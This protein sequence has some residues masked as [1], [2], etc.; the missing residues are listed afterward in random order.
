[1]RK[2]GHLPM[3]HSATLQVCLASKSAA[4]GSVF[5]GRLPNSQLEVEGRP[6]VTSV[7]DDEPTTW[8]YV[9]ET[10]FETLEIPLL[11][12]RHF[13]FS[14]PGPG[15]M[16]VVIVSQSM[17]RKLWPGQDPIGKRFKYNAPGSVAK[18]W[19][20]IVGVVGDT[21]QNGP[22]T[23]P[24]SIIYY[25][26]RQ[27]VWDALVLIARTES[28]PVAMEAAIGDQIHRIDKTIPR[29]EPA[30]VEQQLWELESQRRFQIELLALFSFFAIVLAGV[31][32]YGVMANA[33]G[34]RTREIGIRM[35]LGARRM[36][37]LLMILRQGLIPVVL[38]MAAGL[39]IAFAFSRTLAGLLY[40]ITSTDPITYSSV[41]VLLFSI[42]ALA[43]CVPARRA[44]RVDPLVALRYE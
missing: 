43:A 34:Q 44:T 22:E 38:G 9:S 12:G 40:E 3:R 29:T 35:A 39:A 28:E 24:I 32:M 41:C 8:T 13:T 26:V 17:A 36:D 15:G 42:A 10:F 18:D 11:R 4:I 37:V 1:M 23:R 20:T 16:P 5:L 25:P 33:V 19:L 2:S 6:G 30:T 31:G 14:G 7:I 27:K 21:V